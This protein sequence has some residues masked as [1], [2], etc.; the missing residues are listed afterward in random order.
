MP[1][2]PLQNLKFGSGEPGGSIGVYRLE[3][4]GQ[5]THIM[6]FSQLIAA[7]LAASFTATPPGVAAIRLT[8]A[9]VLGGIIGVEREVNATGAGLRTHILVS[10]AACLFALIAYEM[11]AHHTG[12]K[13][14]PLRL[15]EAV[16]AGVAFLAAGSIIT[17]GGKIKGLTTGAGMWMAG[18]VGLACGTGSLALAALASIIAV[19][20]LWM[21][22]GVS[23]SLSKESAED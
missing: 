6:D 12:D 5:S 13:S 19:I 4:H 3:L 18:A 22:K 20:V 8:A 9:V 15:I 17:S 2:L 1:Q 16:T 7:E 11:L 14:D 10:L 23:R 21:F